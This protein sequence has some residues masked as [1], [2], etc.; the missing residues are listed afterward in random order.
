VGRYTLRADALVGVLRYKVV[1]DALAR[2]RIDLIGEKGL[3]VVVV[4]KK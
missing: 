3:A 4:R 1:F 2:G